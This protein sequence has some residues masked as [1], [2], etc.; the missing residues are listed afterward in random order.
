LQS[1]EAWQENPITISFARRKIVIDGRENLCY[2]IEVVHRDKRA[3]L[4]Q[5]V[6]H[7]TLKKAVYAL[8]TLFSRAFLRV[9]QG[10][11]ATETATILTKLAPDM[12]I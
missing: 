6:E 8:E 5:L 4:A 9:R 1:L 3:P 2:N 11:T 10:F 12:P 7:L